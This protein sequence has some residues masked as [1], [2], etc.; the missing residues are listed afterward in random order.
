M[1]QEYELERIICYLKLI[2]NEYIVL[3]YKPEGNVIIKQQQ[4]MNM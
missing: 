1:L 3:Y 2:R 4:E